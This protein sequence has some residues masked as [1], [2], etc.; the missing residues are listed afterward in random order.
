MS[1]LRYLHVRFKT[2]FVTVVLRNSIVKHDCYVF[3]HNI[4]LQT[5]DLGISTQHEDHCQTPEKHT[6][7]D[8]FKPYIVQ[9]DI[10]HFINNILYMFNNIIN[11]SFLTV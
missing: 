11:Y 4:T 6:R 10:R 8:D 1:I 2:R 9:V 3:N 7:G 5:N